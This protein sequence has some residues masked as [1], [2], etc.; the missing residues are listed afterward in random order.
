MS[1][2]PEAPRVQ[3][4]RIVGAH[5]VKG[6]L[7]VHPLTDYPERFLDMKTLCLERRGKP[8]L[9]LDVVEIASHEGKGQLLLTARGITD[10][11]MAE[12]LRGAVI[13]VSPEERV[14]LPEGEYWIDSLIGLD[15]VEADSGEHLGKVDD[16]M[17]TGSHDIY[18]VRTPDGAAKLLPATAEVVREI[19][20]AGGVM[21][22][23]LLEGLWD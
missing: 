2:S 7:R 19:D 5:G 23:S 9:C 13:T 18:Q 6:V 4:G 14:A 17:S 21:R 15:V 22:V 3:I 8:P 10:R 16:V 1:T 20:L 12:A 11:D